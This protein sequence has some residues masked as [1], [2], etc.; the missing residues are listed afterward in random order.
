MTDEP[1]FEHFPITLAHPHYKAAEIIP[2]PETRSPSGVLLSGGTRS[3]PERYSPVTARNDDDVAYY[4]AQ[5]YEVVGKSDPAAYVKAL[6]APEAMAYVPERY[7][8]W[9]G[10]KLVASAEEERAALSALG[11]AHTPADE[12][13]GQ[14][15]PHAPQ[16]GLLDELAELREMNAR[17]QA[18]LEAQAPRNKGGRPKKAVPAES[19]ASA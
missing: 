3:I 10:D 14:E 18:Q 5:G 1:K 12:E 7:P 19:S 15:I 9:V 13:D 11:E 16:H 2:M 17:L 4:E 6:V 8:M